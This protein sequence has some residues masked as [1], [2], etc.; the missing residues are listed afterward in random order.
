MCKKRKAKISD[1]DTWEKEEKLKANKKQVSKR[2]KEIKIKKIESES[3]KKRYEI[4]EEFPYYLEYSIEKS[5][6]FLSNRF[7]NRCYSNHFVLSCRIAVKEFYFKLY[8][9]VEI[10]DFTPTQINIF[11]DKWFSED[12]YLR[13]KLITNLDDNEKIKQLAVTPLLLTL[14]CLFFEE[15]KQLPINGSELYQE[16]I[17]VLLK[18]WDEEKFVKRDELYKRFSLEHKENLLSEIAFNTFKNNNY[19]FKQNNIEYYIN[20]YISKE[21]ELNRHRI[22]LG[23]DNESI[24]KAIESQH[25]L[26]IERASEIYSFSHLVFQ[27]FFTAKYLY[28]SKKWKDLV[29]Y[30]IQDKRWREVFLIA[31]EISDD[32][33]LKNIKKNIDAIISKNDKIQN[34][35]VWLQT[36]ENMLLDIFEPVSIRAL[37]FAIDININNLINIDANLEDTKS[38][39]LS[40]G[41][42]SLELSY[43]SNMDSNFILDIIFYRILHN[44]VKLNP[45][46]NDSFRIILDLSK[47][48]D[49]ETDL[50]D[51]A[52][53]LPN[54]L[55]FF[56]D[57]SKLWWEIHGKA[58][59]EELRTIMCVYRDIGYDW[60]F[61]NSEIELLHKYYNC[62]VLLVEF[63]NRDNYI[64]PNIREE[65]KNN[66]FLPFAKIDN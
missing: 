20:T 58:W 13:N 23:L 2:E 53:H 45:A 28:N 34:F 57:E 29:Y 41:S 33:N 3:Q 17:K 49:I 5:L 42:K 36:K 22:E 24:L 63:L 10:A 31:L 18:K 26:L 52:N 48:C 40:L 47:N 44:A 65:I 32:D 12:D 1:I 54:N 8:T 62:I 6:A 21:S 14:I 27:E 15:L 38:F 19:L 51:L 11:I 60:K 59:I 30:T 7:P 25:G 46:F 43:K 37:Y 9:E 66:L 35:L 61:D 16:G 50:K 55:M 56:S 64:S 39:S 4:D